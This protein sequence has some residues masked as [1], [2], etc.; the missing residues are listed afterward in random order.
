MNAWDLWQLQPKNNLLLAGYKN[1]STNLAVSSKTANQLSC[2]FFIHLG[3]NYDKFERRV[4]IVGQETFDGNGKSGWVGNAH[5]V[6]DTFSSFVNY[7]QSQPCREYV[8]METQSQWLIDHLE[9]TRSDFH[10][11]LKKISRTKNGIDFLKSGFVWDDLIAVDYKGGSIGKIP[12]SQQNEKNAIWTY[13]KEKLRMEIAIAQPTDIIFFTGEDD[14][15]DLCLEWIFDL[16][17]KV[18]NC[19]S[20]CRGS[21]VEKDVKCFSWNGVQCYRTH[22]PRRMKYLKKTTIIDKLASLF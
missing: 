21:I 6:G 1:F 7:T 3:P 20:L 18:K 5:T 11:A 19:P 9:S 22:H 8:M 16:P 12:K 14:D 10:H 15:Y 17:F 4:F 2:P 13:S